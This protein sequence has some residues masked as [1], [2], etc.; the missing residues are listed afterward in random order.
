M[1][2]FPVAALWSMVIPFPV[3][4]GDSDP[5]TTRRNPEIDAHPHAENE[6]PVSIPPTGVMKTLLTNRRSMCIDLLELHA[7]GGNAV[8]FGD[9]AGM[10]DVQ[11]TSV[12]PVAMSKRNDRWDDITTI[13]LISNTRLQ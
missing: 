12:D 9:D 2:Q 8:R 4:R 3:M 10:H 11:T 1:A 6:T 13:V 5:V 7:V